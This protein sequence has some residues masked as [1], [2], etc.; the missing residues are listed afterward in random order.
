MSKA[1]D[2]FLSRK[3]GVFNHYLYSVQNGDNILRN[4]SGVIMDWNE[5][6]NCFD[7]EKLAFNLNKMGAGYYMF[8]LMQ[9]SRYMCAPNSAYEKYTG[10]KA[11]EACSF[12]DLPADI[13]KALKKYDIDFFLYYTGDGPHIETNFSKNDLVVEPF[14]AKEDFVSKWAEVMQEFAERYGDSVKGWWIDGCYS[15]VGYNDELLEFYHRAAKAGNPDAM[16]ATNFLGVEYYKKGLST[17]EF[18][19]GERNDFD[20][21]PENRYIDGAQS[22]ILAPLGEY[23]NGVVY[24]GWASPGCR[25][26]R[27]F[28]LDYIKKANKI[29]TPVTV[30]IQVYRDGSFNKEQQELLEWVGNRLK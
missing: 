14:E 16:I 23:E 22:H 28:M 8:T 17:E 6:I 2:R 4:P 10:T 5:H 1:T 7:A 27:E 13:I 3:W 26:D 30:D 11:G 21:L 15:W 9:G 18:L 19:C 25:R 12:R 29:G 20:I 24:N